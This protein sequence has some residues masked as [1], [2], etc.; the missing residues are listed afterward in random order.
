M[1]SSA[2][3]CTEQVPDR[4]GDTDLPAP[5]QDKVHRSIDP[6][7]ARLK[8]PDLERRF[9]A[10]RAERDVQQF[11]TAALLAIGV[12]LGFAV[13]DYMV[14]T[15]SHMLA[16]VIRLIWALPVSGAFYVLTYVDFFTQRP[17]LLGW[18]AILPA[19]LLYAAL[20]AVSQAPDIYLSGYIII[21]FFLQILLPLNFVPML[22]IGTVCT[23][24]FAALIPL[25]REIAIGHLLTIYAQYA[26]TL[27]AG[28]FAVY[29]INF[30]RRREFLNSLRIAD[31]RRQ[32]FDL[33]SRILPRSI[34]ARMENGETQIADEIPVASVL[35]ADIVGFTGL[36]ASQPPDAV[37]HHLDTLFKRFDELVERHGLEKIKTIG[38][39]YMVAGG[40]PE[41]RPDFVR[42][43]VELALDMLLAAAK[44]EDP[45]GNRT[46]IRVGI[47]AG[48][49]IAGVIGESRFG[50]DLWGDTVNVASRI[51]AIG[52]P[53][54]VLLTDAVCDALE[55][56]IGLRSLGEVDIK[57]KGAMRVWCL[58][59]GEAENG[60]R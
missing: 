9:Q 2:C 47:H 15:G 40:V 5:P 8:D 37:V 42:A 53:G 31:Q 48:P 39:A 59:T 29:L 18:L 17:A 13:L 24:L 45:D 38:D 43:T 60:S 44:H 33:L 58:N 36:A 27:V 28:T 57:G 51:Q 41:P 6:L 14:V 56:T 32:Y 25:T 1:W 50:Y 11:R 34:V 26:A 7:R 23:V 12:S 3:S 21:L 35:F 54:Q 4:S 16:I 20:C 19:T 49:L 52:E 30:F 55:D 46:R 10:H 22:T